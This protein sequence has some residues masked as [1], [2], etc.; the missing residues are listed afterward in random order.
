MLH[1]ALDG[2][3]N[4][5]RNALECGPH[6]VA[7]RCSNE[8]SENQGWRCA[9]TTSVAACRGWLRWAATTTVGRIGRAWLR[10]FLRMGSAPGAALEFWA[11][12]VAGSP[13]IFSGSCRLPPVDRTVAGPGQNPLRRWIVCA[14]YRVCFPW[15]SLLP[16][17]C[18]GGASCSRRTALANRSVSSLG[19]LGPVVQKGAQPDLSVWMLDHL[20]QH[21]KRHGS[22]IC[23]G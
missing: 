12:L 2:S 3:A 17:S 8:G 23:P 1:I 11:L 22:D 6:L 13:P 9:E 14:E 10:L 20:L 15:R 16:G 18:A 7:A 5:P 19:H 21:R 4:R